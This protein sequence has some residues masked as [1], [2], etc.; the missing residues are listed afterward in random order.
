MDCYCQEGNKPG[1]LSDIECVMCGL[2]V[3]KACYKFTSEVPAYFYC[4]LCLLVMNEPLIGLEK[5]LLEKEVV[6]NKAGILNL[7]LELSEEN[8]LAVSSNKKMILIFLVENGNLDLQIERYEMM[9]NGDSSPFL[10]DRYNIIPWKPQWNNRLRWKSGLLALNFSLMMNYFEKQRTLF[11]FIATR[12]DSSSLYERILQRK[13]STFKDH[14]KIKCLKTIVEE[15]MDNLEQTAYTISL[16]CPITLKLIEYPAKGVRCSHDTFFC[17]KNYIDF[18]IRTEDKALKWRCP[19]CRKKLYFSEI[20]VD[21]DFRQ[22]IKQYGQF[23]LTH[24]RDDDLLDD[25]GQESKAQEDLA[26]YDRIYIRNG[27]IYSYEEF[28]RRFPEIVFE[29]RKE[30]GHEKTSLAPRSPKQT[31]KLTPNKLSNPFSEVQ[32]SDEKYMVELVSESQGPPQKPRE[33]G[34]EKKDQSGSRSKSSSSQFIHFSKSVIQ[35]EEIIL[36]PDPTQ[37]DLSPAETQPKQT[38]PSKS[39]VKQKSSKKKN[40]EEEFIQ[41]RGRAESKEKS[42]NPKPHSPKQHK[43]DFQSPTLIEIKLYKNPKHL[44]Q[45]VEKEMSLEITR[46]MEPDI[47]NYDA[48]NNLISII[49][50]LYIICTKVMEADLNLR[51]FFCMVWLCSGLLA[52]H[53]SSARST[54]LNTNLYYNAGRLF[55]CFNQTMLQNSEVSAERI[56]RSIRKSGAVFCLDLKEFSEGYFEQVTS[57]TSFLIGWSEQSAELSQTKELEFVM[58]QQVKGM[59]YFFGDFGSSKPQTSK[60]QEQPQRSS[61]SVR[62]VILMFQ[63]TSLKLLS[64]ILSSGLPVQNQQIQMVIYR[65]FLSKLPHLTDQQQSRHGAD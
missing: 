20:F 58:E 18:N 4:E 53:W 35:E 15:N 1:D 46:R 37:L 22:V 38:N 25:S 45:E 3:H 57:L 12:V 36:D 48:P 65:H 30:E 32:T 2:K 56:F 17:M 13:V 34:S 50:S 61:D 43:I 6:C 54:G 39:P 47:I 51:Q 27:E 41:P 60:Q 9:V 33:R 29:R 10:T 14:R 44:Q 7:Q 19:I 63:K 23:M 64:I 49:D 16:L 40:I 26:R 21:D 11:I 5:L 52:R 62:R 24:Q 8:F 28:E 59:G 55:C 42:S 31:M